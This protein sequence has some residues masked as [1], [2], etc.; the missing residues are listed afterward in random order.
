MMVLMMG[1]VMLAACGGNGNSTA[2]GGGDTPPEKL[3]ITAIPDANADELKEMYGE[4][5]KYIEAKTGIPTEYYHVADYKASVTAI[6]TN[7]AQISW[8]GGVTTVQA[9]KAAEVEVLACRDI[10]KEFVTYFI[11][12]KD[13]GVSECKDLKEVAE[14]A[15]GKKFTFGSPGSTS[16]HIMPRHYFNTQAGASPEDTFSNVSYSGS[17]SKTIEDVAAGTAAIG[18]VNFKYWDKAD[19]A[20]KAKAPIIYKTPSYVDYSFVVRKDVGQTTIKKIRAALL[21]LNMDTPEGKKILEAFGAGKFVK[22]DISEWDGIKAVMDS[23]VN[24]GG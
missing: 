11:A 7:Q 23:G 1:V 4:V 19:A 10:D 2:D 17:H 20:T 14:K 18:A 16:G 13:A 6:Q 9:S 15:K 3:V 5:A 12:N 24:I 8:M 21:E 22:A